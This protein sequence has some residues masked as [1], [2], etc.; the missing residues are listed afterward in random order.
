[1]F[2]FEVKITNAEHRGGKYF[3][4][5]AVGKLNASMSLSL[6]SIRRKTQQILQQLFN[7]NAIPFQQEIE[8][9]CVPELVEFVY[10]IYPARGHPGPI[11]KTFTNRL[12]LL[13]Y[14][15]T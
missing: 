15:C 4:C 6:G 14:K 2:Q 12:G 3:S 1:M 7:C 8:N 13:I 9:Y 10:L 5:I 11:L